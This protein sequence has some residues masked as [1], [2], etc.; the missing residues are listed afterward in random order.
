MINYSIFKPLSETLNNYHI[1]WGIGGSCLLQLYNLYDDPNDLDLWVQP[2][3]MP[4][5]KEIFCGFE[6]LKSNLP[7]PEEYRFKIKY[8]DLEVD[9]I[10]CFM[11][12]PNQH[13]FEYK[14]EPN[15]IK[16]I[17][18]EGFKIPCTYLEDWYII[19]RLL[20]RNEKADLI[21]NVFESKRIAINDTAIEA[22]ISNKLVTI[23]FRIKKD[24]YD[25]VTAATQMKISDY[26]EL[27]LAIV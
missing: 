4:Q 20:G 23:P 2:S 18:Y 5:V 16:L 22:A 17:D 14:I 27:G 1:I 6:E 8:F 7:L 11:T 19:Y 13:R 15:N 21:Q 10:A 3:D 25:L 12:K 26:S 9:F 24:V